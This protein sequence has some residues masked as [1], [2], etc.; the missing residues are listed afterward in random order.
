[1]GLVLFVALDQ[2]EGYILQP[3]VMGYEVNLHPAVVIVAFL[4]A[5][6]LLGL[7]GL[8]L[9]VPDAAVCATLR[10]ESFPEVPSG[11]KPSGRRW[12][13]TGRPAWNRAGGQLNR[14]LTLP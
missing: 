1:V 6:A 2:I 10:E 14:N 13:D 7:F 3:M 9:A 12:P 5:G 11:D 8:L 4:M